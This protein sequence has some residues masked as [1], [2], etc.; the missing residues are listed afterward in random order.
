MTKK[1]RM[2]SVH[3]NPSFNPL[4]KNQILWH[5][6]VHQ[7]R[8][9]DGSAMV[10]VRIGDYATHIDEHFLQSIASVPETKTIKLVIAKCPEIPP[11]VCALLAKHISPK[12]LEIHV[13]DCP[14][15][16]WNSH[17]KRILEA[18]GSTVDHINLCNNRWVNDWVV[19]QISVK[20]SKVCHMLCGSVGYAVCA[21]VGL[22]LGYAVCAVCAGCAG[23]MQF[24]V[25]QRSM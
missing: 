3:V 22:G 4:V 16:G 9:D 24:I 2:A 21:Y 10:E 25:V 12:L 5:K 7:V 13:I 15:L 23:C 17:I 14:D 18:C 8:R 6:C 19:E 11:D 1:V 20:F